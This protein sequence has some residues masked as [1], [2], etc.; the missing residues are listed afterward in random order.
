MNPLPPLPLKPDSSGRL[1]LFLD[2]SLM[3]TLTTCPRSFE[4][5]FLRKRRATGERAALNFGTGIHS[6]L[7]AR[8]VHDDYGFVNGAV[9]Q[10]MF[11]ALTKHFDEH[12]NPDDEYRNL[13]YATK[14]IQGYNNKFMT[15]DFEVCQMQDGK[16]CVEMS[17]AVPLGEKDNPHLFVAKGED[18]DVIFHVMYTGRIDLVIREHGTQLYTFDHKTAF[19]FGS[20]YWLDQQMSGQHVGYCSI[21]DEVLGV[22]TVGYIVNALKTRKMSKTKPDFE[23]EDFE[24]NRYYITKERKAEW[25][26]NLI[27][28]IEEFLWNYS[29]GY[30]PMRTKWCV[31]KYGACQFLD[32]CSVG[33]D[34]RLL[35]LESG[36]YEEN[37]WSPLKQVKP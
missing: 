6:A 31:G 21:V 29:R 23:S 4:Y 7:E 15:E 11:N 8:Y 12:P 9:E 36:L 16:K 13:D 22:E 37:D 30:M 25:K 20:T 33:E 35:T 32:V 19:M 27:A 5:S 17:F 1:W 28:T 24:R 14:M 26:R 3:E 2:N 10:S 34:Q 18:K